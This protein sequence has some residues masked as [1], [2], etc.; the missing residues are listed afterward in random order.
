MRPMVEFCEGNLESFS[1]SVRLKLESEGDLD[2]VEYGC[3]GNCGECYAR[4]FAYVNGKRLV[5][6]TAEELFLEIKNCIRKM[7][8]ED[9]AWKK[10]GL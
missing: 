1:E 6:A 8:E 10:L 5:A 9:E 2:L 4:P 3:L 7:Q